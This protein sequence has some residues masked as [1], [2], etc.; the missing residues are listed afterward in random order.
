LKKARKI[1]KANQK[2][3]TKQI[4]QIRMMI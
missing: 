4:N 3:K 1:N 2:D